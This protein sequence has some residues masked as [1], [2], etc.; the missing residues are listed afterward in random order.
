MPISRTR[1]PSASASRISAAIRPRMPVAVT[2]P[3]S[4]FVPKQSAARIDSLCAASMPS[5]SKVGSAS[6]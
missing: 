5:T 2:A 4:S 6:A 1:W 3:I